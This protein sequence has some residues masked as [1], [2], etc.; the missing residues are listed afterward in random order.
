MLIDSHAHLTDHRFEKDRDEIIRNLMRDGIE[1]VI[2]SGGDMESNCAA[3]SLAE[4][5]DTIYAS[6]GINCGRQNDYNMIDKIRLY[7][8][9]KKIVAIGEIGLDYHHFPD[10][11]EIQYIPLYSDYDHFSAIK[12]F[13]YYITLS[14]DYTANHVL[15]LYLFSHSQ[16]LLLHM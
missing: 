16:L 13:D 8:R 1:K 11:K 14:N 15:R 4:K 5:Y 10:E 7:L 3:A 9:S 6:V 2:T 12:H